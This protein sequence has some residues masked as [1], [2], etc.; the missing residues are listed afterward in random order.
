[1]RI[2]GPKRDEVTREW[3]KLHNVELHD[4]QSSNNV[5]VT[6]S[7]RVSWAG[8]CSTYGGEERCV[9]DFGEGVL[10]RRRR[11]WECNVSRDSNP[12]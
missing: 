9:Q 6:K 3:R 5:R 10:G 1:M 2:F 8:T 12:T 11:R 7:K 4:L